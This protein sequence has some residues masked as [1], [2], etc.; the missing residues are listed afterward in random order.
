MLNQHANREVKIMEK[1][2]Y[3]LVY[4]ALMLSYSVDIIAEKLKTQTLVIY[5]CLH[6]TDP[7]IRLQRIAE[8]LNALTDAVMESNKAKVKSDDLVDL[9]KIKF[10][11]VNEIIS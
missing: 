7:L 3:E 2:N 9:L 5:S 8:C 1:T 4:E 10:N 11:L 6:E